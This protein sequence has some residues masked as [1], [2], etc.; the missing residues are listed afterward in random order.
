[1]LQIRAIV[2]DVL[3]LLRYGRSEYNFNQYAK[4]KKASFIDGVLLP[5]T[6]GKKSLKVINVSK[7]TMSRH[8]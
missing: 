4:K 8:T 6:A 1:M 5:A 3:L 7:S 2:K